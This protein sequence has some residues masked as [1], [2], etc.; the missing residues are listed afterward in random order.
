MTESDQAVL[1]CFDA[2]RRRTIDLLRQTPADWLSRQAQGEDHALGR[3]YLHIAD[4][5][6]WWLHFCLKDG[7]PKD[8]PAASEND[9]AAIQ[10]ALESS[11]QRLLRF[12][13]A[14]AGSR[15]GQTFVL[16]PRELPN[17]EDGPVE[18]FTGRN[19]VLYLTA[20][21]IHHR[22]KLVLALRQWGMADIPFL[23]F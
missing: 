23:P 12:F 5:P 22:G 10:I 6:D 14:D 21:E 7:L 16:N 18:Q 9:P 3:L 13:T 11:Q 15:M 17:P 8:G 1:D 2:T 19:R 4:S 20:H